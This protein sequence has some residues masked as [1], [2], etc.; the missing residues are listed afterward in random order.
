MTQCMQSWIPSPGAQAHSPRYPVASGGR[1]THLQPPGLISRLQPQELG[2]RAC[3]PVPP[4][5][6]L[7]HSSSLPTPHPTWFIVNS[8]SFL[9]NYLLS[10]EAIPN[11]TMENRNASAPLTASMSSLYHSSY[12]HPTEGLEKQ[13]WGDEFRKKCREACLAVVT[14]GQRDEKHYRVS[15]RRKWH[16]TPV[17]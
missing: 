11:N 17:F 1:H 10:S 8:G 4:G 16:P 13:E 14:S 3:S 15:W 9:S 12:P 5:A 6:G 7:A 2:S